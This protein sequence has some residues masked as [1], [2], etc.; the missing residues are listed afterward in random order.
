[1]TGGGG[2]ENKAQRSDLLWAC[3]VELTGFDD[4]YKAE[5]KKEINMISWFSARAPSYIYRKGD[6]CKSKGFRG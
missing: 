6:H 1:M 3:E 4:G 2:R 5:R